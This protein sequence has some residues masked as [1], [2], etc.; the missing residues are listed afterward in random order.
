MA[1]EGPRVLYNPEESS[2]YIETGGPSMTVEGL[3]DECAF[4]RLLPD[5]DSASALWLKPAEAEVLASM[6]KHVLGNIRIRPESQ[7]A[8]EAILPRIES[9]AAGRGDA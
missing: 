3:F 2:L 4:E 7:A 6:V 8:L 5:G 9:L 1:V